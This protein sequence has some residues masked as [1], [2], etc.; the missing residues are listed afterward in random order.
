[1]V[2]ESIILPL[3]GGSGDSFT[4]YN[5]YGKVVKLE[6]RGRSLVPEFVRARVGEKGM[7]AGRGGLKRRRA[8]AT[9]QTTLLANCG[10]RLCSIASRDLSGAERKCS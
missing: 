7:G 3:V 6:G 1:M 8:C 2:V 9:V 10:R 4:P 5:S